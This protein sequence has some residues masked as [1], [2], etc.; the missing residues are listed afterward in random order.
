MTP[1]SILLILVSAIL[2]SVW[3]F[4]SK[5]G[6]WPLE[7]FFLVFLRGTL[8]YLPFFMTLRSF[9]ALLFDAPLRVWYLSILSGLILI[10]VAR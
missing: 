6:N 3:N 4:F 2:H 8:L 10:G 1:F 9:P 5:K 7:F